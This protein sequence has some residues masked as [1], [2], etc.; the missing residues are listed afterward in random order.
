MLSRLATRLPR[1]ASAL[2]A[3]STEEADALL[4]SEREGMVRD[5]RFV[6]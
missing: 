2:R 6:P 4:T 1:P 5:Y 3:F